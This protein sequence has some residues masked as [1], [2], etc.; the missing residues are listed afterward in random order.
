[1]R[2][3]NI[4]FSFQMHLAVTSS[5]A[6]KFHNFVSSWKDR[7]VTENQLSQCSE[8]FMGRHADLVSNVTTLHQN[9][10]VSKT[11]YRTYNRYKV[12]RL[13]EC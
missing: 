6:K 11:P 3:K 4:F 8:W 9:N 2:L 13:N 1:M 12:E 7:N 5:M 10:D